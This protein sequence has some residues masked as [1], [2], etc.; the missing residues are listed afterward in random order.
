MAERTGYPVEML[1][2]DALLE[3]DL[4]IDSIK[5][6]EIFGSLTDYHRFMPGGGGFDEELLAEFAQLKTL[7]DIIAMYDRGRT[8][9]IAGA[10]P[11][12]TGTAAEP[13]NG[14]TAVGNGNGNGAPAAAHGAAMSANGATPAVNG[15]KPAVHGATAAG[16]GATAAGNGAAK[17]AGNGHAA[18]SLERL[19]VRPVPAPPADVQK[20][21]YPLT[22][23][24]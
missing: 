15:A 22:T 20:K 8:G 9:G 24:S 1:K 4:G 11:R 12:A 23:S 16:N 14:T 18:G 5:T 17:P 10:T 13:V 3:A 6:V 21:N 2:E 7:G 19:E